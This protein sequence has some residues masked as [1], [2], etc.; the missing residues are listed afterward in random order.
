MPMW[1]WIAIGLG[2]FFG[3][4]L[5]AGFAI[6]RILRAIGR[7]ISELYET[8]EWAMM[9]PSRAPRDVNDQKPDDV[10]AYSSRVVRLR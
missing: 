1:V 7:Q 5:V 6:A 10:E 4:S 9:P 3:L 8:D 2:S